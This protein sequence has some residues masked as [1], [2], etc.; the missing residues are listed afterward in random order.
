[1]RYMERDL[2]NT[3]YYLCSLRKT[4][5]YYLNQARLARSYRGRGLLVGRDLLRE[6][7][8]EPLEM[9]KLPRYLITPLRISQ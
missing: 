9:R 4:I 2:R 7:H 6:P 5:K 8:I 3:G 1:M